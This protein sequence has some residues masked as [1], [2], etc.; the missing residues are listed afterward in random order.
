MGRH[1]SG[2]S[3]VK[4][5][6]VILVMAGT[7]LLADRVKMRSGQVV[8]GDFMSADVK[9]VTAGLRKASFSASP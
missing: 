6:A 4:A 5:I 7:T 1:A 2:V 3:I 9:V 8:T